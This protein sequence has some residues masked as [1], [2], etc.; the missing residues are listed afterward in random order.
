VHPTQDKAISQPTSKVGHPRTP[1]CQKYFH[2]GAP[3][4]EMGFPKSKTLRIE[5]YFLTRV[6]SPERY[7]HGL[8]GSYRSLALNPH[9]TQGHAATGAEPNKCSLPTQLVDCRYSRG[10]S[11]RVTGVRVRDPGA[12]SNGARCQNDSGHCDV[13]IACRQALVVH[14]APAATE[15]LG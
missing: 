13:Y 1:A 7:H 9:G 8:D 5:V 11:A 15:I 10:G 12:D 4:F 14:P 3:I 6:K 2:V